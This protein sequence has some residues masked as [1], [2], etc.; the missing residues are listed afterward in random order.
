MTNWE[1]LL[2]IYIGGFFGWCFV[3]SYKREAM[4]KDYF[5]SAAIWPVMII[6][7]TALKL[8]YLIHGGPRRR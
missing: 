2:A 4:D 6:H 3:M 1:N 8:S 7:M 5:I